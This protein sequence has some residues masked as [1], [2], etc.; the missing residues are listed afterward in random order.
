MIGDL[1]ASLP[2]T[3]DARAIVDRAGEI[4]KQRGE[5]AATSVDLL[6]ATSQLQPRLVAAARAG[7]SPD[8]SPGLPVERLLTYANREAQSMGQHQVTPVHL[9]LAM[10]YSDSPATA[11][12]LQQ[13]GL[14]LYGVRQQ[15]QQAPRLGPAVRS[16]GVN[17]S[18]VFLGIVGVAAISGA[19]LWTDLYPGLVVPLTLTFVVAGWVVSLC[20]HEFGHAFVAYLGG[21]RAVAASGYLTL[22]P[23]RYTNVVL[24]IVLPVFFLLIGGIALP[25][26]A[27]YINHSALRGRGWSSAV[28]LAGPAGTFLCWLVVAGFFTFA[29]PRNVINADNI[30]FFAA[31]AVLGFFLTFALVLNLLPVPGLDGFGVIRPWLSRELQYSLM[32]YGLLAIL[33]V[34]AVLWFV[35]PVRDVFFQLIF[36]I[37]TVGGIPLQLLYVG[38][39]DMRI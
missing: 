36:Q 32:R 31:L 30:T 33:G 7:P 28:S 29:V 12:P 24:S 16:S 20:I 1:S 9:L 15:A 8:G 5:S 23:L 17:I 3:R 35:A 27:V 19:L 4:A 22:N 13:V 6:E 18:P 38:L 14:T 34:Y 26:G 2:L 39:L 25:G 37:T 11:V 10:L 21:D